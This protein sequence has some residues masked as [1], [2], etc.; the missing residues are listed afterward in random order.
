MSIK[1]SPLRAG[2]NRLREDATVTAVGRKAS[3]DAMENDT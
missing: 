1:D 3:I 2:Q